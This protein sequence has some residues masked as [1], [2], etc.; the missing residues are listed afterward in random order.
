MLVTVVLTLRQE[1]HLAAR[2]NFYRDI[3]LSQYRSWIDA[4]Y[5][6][7]DFVAWLDSGNSEIYR[8]FV[9]LY[10]G[11]SLLSSY[12]T[13]WSSYC[14]ACGWFTRP[15][16]SA[17]PRGTDRVHIRF[18]MNRN[19]GDKTDV[20][21]DDVTLKVR[22][23]GSAT[24]SDA[25]FDDNSLIL[26]PIYT[27]ENLSGNNAVTRLSLPQSVESQARRLMQYG[28]RQDFISAGA[29]TYHVRLPYR[30]YTS[31]TLHVLL[32][33]PL[34][35]RSSI[36]I[37]LDVGA[38]A[39]I[40]WQ[41][42]GFPL[43]PGTLTSSDLAVALT[44]YILSQVPDSEGMV[45]IPIRANLS[46]GGVFFL[47]NLVVTPGLAVDASIG[48]G[49][50]TFGGAAA[51]QASS[52]GAEA[53]GLQNKSRSRPA[54]WAAP[55]GR[56]TGLPLG[57]PRPQPRAEVQRRPTSLPKATPSPSTPRSIM[58]GS[59][60]SGPLTASFFATPAGVPPPGGREWYIGSAFVAN[61]SAGGTATAPLQ[62]NTLGF[63]GD[64][65]VRV[66]VDPFN[67]LPETNET[68]NQATANITI[69]TRPD[70][71][72]PALTLSDPE[73]RAGEAV[74]VTISL[75]N[76][77][78]TQ[79]AAQTVALYDGNPD[80][81]GTIVGAGLAPALPGAAND[82]VAFIWTPSTPGLHRL[83]AMG[84]H[85]GVV[86]ESD[87]GNNQTWLDVYVGFGGAILL[88]SG[89]GEAYDPAYSAALG[90]GYL[91]GDPSHPCGVE[92]D[93][94]QRSS[95]LGEVKYRFDHLLPGHFYHLDVT[96]YDCE[97]LGRLQ[98]ITV[99]DP[100]NI[101][102]D[103]IDLSDGEPHRLSFRLDPALYANDR[104]IEVAIKEL[105]G[106]DA[107]VA[108]VNLHDIDYRYADAGGGKDPAYTPS[109]GYGWLDG[110]VLT[111]W[112]TLPYQSRRYERGGDSTADDPDN[113]LRYQFDNLD[114]TKHYQVHLTIYQGGG[115][116]TI[117]QS[118]A[119]DEVDTGV[120]ATVTGVQR[121]YKTV[122]VPIG[123]YAE[124]GSIIV[125]ITRLNALAGAWVNEIAL[126][127]LTLPAQVTQALSL[128]GV[129]PNWLS[130]NIKPPVRPLVACSGVNPTSAFTTLSGDVLLAGSAAPVN[131]VVE[132]Y[133]P[134]GV[135]VGCFKV[136]TA[137]KYG[138]M[139]VHGAEGGTPG[140]QTGEPI[141]F[142]VNGISAQPSPYPVL[143]QNDKLTRDVDLSAPDV[144]PVEVFLNSASGVSKLQSESGT[145]LPPPAD[146][147]FNTLTTVEPGQG[148]L[149]YATAVMNL[150][151]SGARVPADTPIAL[152]AG[153]NWLGYLPTCELPVAT[154]LASIAGNYD[155]LHSE[156]FNDTGGT[157]RPPPANPALNN[158]NSMAPGRGYMI[159]MTQAATLIYPAAACGLA[160]SKFW[161]RAASCR[162]PGDRHRPLHSLLRP[163]PGR[164][165]APRPRRRDSSAQPP[166][167]GRWLRPSQG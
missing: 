61:V 21:V 10:S 140:M 56:F 148:Y 90:F 45:T 122:D 109:G 153:W 76:D 42:T 46:A 95:L 85:T 99:D 49:D 12:D 145:Y 125:R 130:I 138:Y 159:H 131:T 108:E 112:G 39:S 79:A 113:E 128:H 77:G 114:P 105:T 139:G 120:V 59:L 155:I 106:N 98:Q 13:G 142:K 64:V 164:R 52:P 157:Y 121:V 136:H 38:N 167:R 68:N 87:E 117:Q 62:W 111:A 26:Y 18:E 9:G 93:Q 134:V 141:F 135:K 1:H 124:D 31:A 92:A 100:E 19:D 165:Q 150:I 41:A 116:A 3:S 54:G 72:L 15:Y 144:I 27:V 43:F 101:L 36:Q 60:D 50:V 97:G 71:R 37:Q 89:G 69:R 156:R 86:N 91:N 75:R 58:P 7:L 2:Q 33:D 66:V 17:I 107:I 146:P 119:I 104:A 25:Y 88:D 67:R 133:T 57:S 20:D 161:P 96:L 162:L 80:A 28:L 115:A 149:L 8:V 129:S 35:D 127:E 110:D 82:T 5:G 32:R 160:A 158:F 4:G 152:H 63:T 166:R 11:S 34:A 23:A 143:W 94:T 48:A 126:E 51:V 44:S 151:L 103:A 22:F 154:A 47:T 137:G 40:D 65:P 70:L 74:N 55:P 123:V 102:A 163:N 147:R 6:T 30:S 132:A 24:A 29:T 83:F 78:Q 73:P 81:G 16:Q 118:I 84:D 14:G 53:S